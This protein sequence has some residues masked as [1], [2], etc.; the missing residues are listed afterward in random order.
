M[1][2]SLSSI[3][4]ISVVW[5]LIITTLFVRRQSP[6]RRTTKALSDT[7]VVYEGGSG[8][9]VGRRRPLPAESLYRSDPD[10]EIELVEAEP[11]QVV[12]DDTI[13]P[14]GAVA[15]ETASNPE[16]VIPAVIDGD[17]VEYRTLDEEDTGEF[18]AIVGDADLNGGSGAAGD[19]ATVD[20][21]DTADT[22]DVVSA[23]EAA[24]GTEVTDG[25]GDAEGAEGTEAAETRD[26]T[27]A[28]EPLRRRFAVVDDAYIRGGDI[29]ITIGTDDELPLSSLAGSTATTDRDDE[30]S[31]RRVD[32]HDED[33]T[34]D[35]LD[36]AASRR[37]RGIYDP[38]ASRG[39][40]EQ[41]QRRRFRVL[42]VLA[43]VTVLSLVGAVA[44]GGA[45]WAVLTAGVLVTVGYLYSL[46]KQTVAERELQHRRLARM[47][48]ARLG[49]RNT[50]D[51]ELG[52]PNRLL[53]PG[54][55]VVETDD[56]DPEFAELG[57]SDVTFADYEDYSDSDRYH[58]Y[59]NYGDGHPT[60]R[61]I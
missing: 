10:V 3:I 50:D 6:V 17:I 23:V 41:R 18:P 12:I 32:D 58:N 29:D 39:L 9:A 35:D 42:A 27:E 44:L 5:L 34:D 21:V 45:L 37:G 48:R 11:E 55:V 52:V 16:M 15:D 22:D 60:I 54:A 4:L 25:T 14:T 2:S 13:E 43:S 20:T 40:A 46:R 61:V 24:E 47:R 7:R 36:Y 49:V 28:P 57:Y 19:D 56:T 1:S 38:V 31:L 59:D 26:L 33:L 53:R 8:L 30:D 51:L